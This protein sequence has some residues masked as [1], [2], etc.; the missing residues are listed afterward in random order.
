MERRNFIKLTSI[1]A[2]G[3]PSA[4]VYRQIGEMVRDVK[5]ALQG[6]VII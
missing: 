5:Q 6:Q 2:A 4:E 1:A 3:F